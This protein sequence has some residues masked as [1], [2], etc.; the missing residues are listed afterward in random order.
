MVRRAFRAILRKFLAPSSGDL[1]PQAV[2]AFIRR[3]LRAMLSVLG[4]A[5]GVSAV[6]AT[7]SVVEGATQ[8]TLADAERLGLDTVVLRPLAPSLQRP[9]NLSRGLTIRDAIGLRSLGA[10]VTSIDV[11]V[12]GGAE[13]VGPAKTQFGWV[14]A[15]TPDYAAATRL[16]AHRG[17]LPTRVDADAG[18]RVCLVGAALARDLYGAADPIGHSLGI[19]P[20]QYIVVGVLAEQRS[21]G[22]PAYP[23]VPTVDTDRVVIVPLAA[24]LGHAPEEDPWRPV[25]EIR[26]RVSDPDEVEAMGGVLVRALAASHPGEPAYAVVVPRALV[27]QRMR[28]QRTFGFV[29]G[30]VALLTLAVGGI[31]IMNV[32]LA[33]V[34]ERIPEIGIRRSVGATRR[35]IA[36]L[37]VFETAA[38]GV[39]G[40]GVGLLGGMAASR[41][42]AVYAGW[43][44][45]I[46]LVGVA[47]ALVVACVVGITSGAY[48]A[49][50]ASTIA[51]S[52]AVRYE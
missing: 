42:V 38:L 35:Q 1:V 12:E 16:R 3:P 14:I 8:Q 31:G 34:F 13:L 20:E 4:V 17:R 18:S 32:T 45:H 49:W 2:E 23:G 39:A 44:T 28:M 30:S 51:P 11:V 27:E 40:G 7:L 21:T 24:R 29:F 50:R 36:A 19:G 47:A 10:A 43:N 5:I 46:S 48:P 26:V 25:D 41:A 22:R 15:T 33:S 6:V 52:E 9:A 37:F